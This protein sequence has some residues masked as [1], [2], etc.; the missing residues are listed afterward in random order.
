[1]GVLYKKARFFPAHCLEKICKF[2]FLLSVNCG[3]I[4]VYKMHAEYTKNSAYYRKVRCCAM[5]YTVT[6]NPALDYVVQCTQLVP[7]GITRPHTTV[8]QLGGKGVNVSQILRCLNIDNVAMGIVA[9]ATGAVLEQGLQEMGIQ[10]EFVHIPRGLTRINVKLTAQTDTEVNALGPTVH[11]QALEPL[12]A[13]LRTLQ[14]GDVLVLAGSVPP[15]LSVTI[16]RT[17]LQQVEG[18]GVYTVVDAAGVLLEESLPGAPWLIKPNHIEL[19]ELA[20]CALT[21]EAALVNAARDLQR[22]GAR[23]VLISIASEGALL[24]TQEGLLYRAKAP[25]GRVKNAVGAGDSMVAGFLAGYQENN[26]MAQALRWGVAAGSATAF[27]C[28]LADGAQI[29]QMLDETE[30]PILVEQP[31]ECVLY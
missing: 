28:Q 21:S 11:P 13:R 22:R 16:Y 18:K 27:C 7:G 10:T 30:H 9:G 12:L 26:D 31:E 15:G 25:S 19:E 2:A 3:I 4:I 23:N 1:M 29:Q 17:L 14:A 24:L 5:I 8:L 6:L 20:G